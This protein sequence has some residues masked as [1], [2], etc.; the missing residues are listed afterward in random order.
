MNAQVRKIPEHEAIYLRVRD[1]IMFGE[2]VPG[3]S[4]TIQGL[5]ET[6]GAGMTPVREAIRRLT[7]EGAL[8]ALGNRRIEVASSFARSARRAAFLPGVRLSQNLRK[9]R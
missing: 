5:T 4:V 7:S 3:Q 8:L 9:W 2:L 1:A 6:I